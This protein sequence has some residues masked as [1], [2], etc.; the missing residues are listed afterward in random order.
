MNELANE[1]NVSCMRG[2]YSFQMDGY[3]IYNITGYGGNVDQ[4]GNEYST[5]AVYGPTEDACLN[6]VAN[7]IR[8]VA[9]VLSCVKPEGGNVGIRDVSIVWRLSPEV[10]ERTYSGKEIEDGEYI[11]GKTCIADWRMNVYPGNLLVT[12]PTKISDLEMMTK[13]VEKEFHRVFRRPLTDIYSFSLKPA[14][15]SSIFKRG[16]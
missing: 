7:K 12:P 9:S 5:Y 4:Y 15:E 6:A 14:D 8:S 10:R 2:G 11:K 1:L 16:I 3:K 13:V